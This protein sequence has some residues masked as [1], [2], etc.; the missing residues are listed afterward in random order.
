M[1][2]LFS[3][4][5]DLGQFCA[6]FGGTDPHEPTQR[7]AEQRLVGQVSVNV[8]VFFKRRM[9]PGTFKGTFSHKSL[10]Q[11]FILH[12]HP[13]ASSPGGAGILK[14]PLTRTGAFKATFVCVQ[15]RKKLLQ[16]SWFA[17]LK[18]HGISVSSLWLPASRPQ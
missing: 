10:L 6:S 16:S 5:M 15:N 8:V 3:A 7:A 17:G 2:A 13:S 1:I 9:L 12:E 14:S 4:A 18:G 11:M